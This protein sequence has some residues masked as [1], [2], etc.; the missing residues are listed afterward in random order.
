[1]ELLFFL[2]AILIRVMFSSSPMTFSIYEKASGVIS[3]KFDI[4]GVGAEVVVLIG[5]L[6]LISVFGEW[7]G[8]WIVDLLAGVV[9]IWCFLSWGQFDLWTKT[10]TVSSSERGELIALINQFGDEH[11]DDKGQPLSALQSK[12]QIKTLNYYFLSVFVLLFC[13][14]FLG[15]FGLLLYVFLYAVP[16]QENSLFKDAMKKIV[17][18]P[19]ALLTT[20]PTAVSGSFSAV[21]Q[22]CKQFQF[23]ELID[24][25]GVFIGNVIAAAGEAEKGEGAFEEFRT[26]LIR[27]VYVILFC[28]S[29]YVVL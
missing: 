13:Y 2:A 8:A 16:T 22:E 26:L 27:A 4:K 18:C 20:F 12:L 17:E 10:H 25:R 3:D 5:V 21:I 11:V 7:F 15:L 23:S 14:L 9:F 28:Y 6:A 24:G 29:V 19:A 1:M